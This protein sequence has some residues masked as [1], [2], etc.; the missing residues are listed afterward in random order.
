MDLSVLWFWIVAFTLIYGTLAVVEVRLVLRAI[1]K[2]PPE[3]GEPDP[4]SGRI[5]PAATV[6]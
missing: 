6:Y 1:R 2:G 4:E 3:L 5:E